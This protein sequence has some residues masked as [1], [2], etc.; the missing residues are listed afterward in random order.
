MSFFSE[1]HADHNFETI[2]QSYSILKRD[3]HGVHP[4]ANQDSKQ[5]SHSIYTKTFISAEPHPP[6]KHLHF[7]SSH[8]PHI[9]TFISIP[10][11]KPSF[12]QDF[13]G[14]IQ[15]I[16]LCGSATGFA[17]R[18]RVP[19]QFHVP[20]KYSSTPGSSFVLF[21]HTL[22]HA[23]FT[24]TDLYIS[25]STDFLLYLLHT[26]NATSSTQVFG[27]LGLR[28]GSSRQWIGH[29]LVNVLGGRAL[30]IRLCIVPGWFVGWKLDF[31]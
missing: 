22:L 3:L 23:H 31:S 24:T 20:T 15:S 14:E 27:L 4:T 10:I 1:L 7:I 30:P 8:I 18:L 26:T 21:L 9:P 2:P 12:S 6:D 11:L 25:L 28:R 29:P 5:L 17:R 16:P 13:E 19:S